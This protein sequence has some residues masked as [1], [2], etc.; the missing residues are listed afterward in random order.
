MNRGGVTLSAACHS[1]LTPATRCATALQS[2]DALNAIIADT[3]SD[4]SAQHDALSEAFAMEINAIVRHFYLPEQERSLEMQAVLILGRHR[5]DSAGTAEAEEEV[6]VED[7]GT[8][9]VGDTPS[10]GDGGAVG[11]A[12]GGGD[13]LDAAAAEGAVAGS[14]SLTTVQE[15]CVSPFFVVCSSLLL[16][17][18]PQLGLCHVM[19]SVLEFGFKSKTMFGANRHVWDFVTRVSQQLK[20]TALSMSS[21]PA[22]M[23]HSAVERANLMGYPK[24][25]RFEWLVCCGASAHILHV[26]MELV[27][28]GGFITCEVR[29]PLTLSRALCVCVCSWRMR[30]G[31]RVCLMGRR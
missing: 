10:G 18:P 28:E 30:R 17:P 6:E 19:L 14:D 21:D 15:V 5:I 2:Q 8:E 16:T 27:G 29:W 3:G 25:A 24:T 4:I 9:A 7:A 26:W 31:R 22:S 11:D 23:L 13:A 1:G 20:P 12:A